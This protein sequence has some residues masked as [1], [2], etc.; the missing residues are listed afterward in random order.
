MSGISITFWMSSE[1]NLKVESE[2]MGTMLAQLTNRQPNPLTTE[3]TRDCHCQ[4]TQCYLP[5]GP[6]QPS[7][8]AERILHPMPVKT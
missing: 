1:V 2:P 3:V 7:H 8:T 6:S 5:P 4:Q